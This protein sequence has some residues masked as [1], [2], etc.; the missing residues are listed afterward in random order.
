MH[1]TWARVAVAALCAVLLAGCGQPGLGVASNVGGHK[2]TDEQAAS[3]ADLLCALVAVD[4][5]A[6]SRAMINKQALASLID[7]ELTR[8]YAKKE[9][10]TADPTLVTELSQ[11]GLTFVDQLPK[12]NRE[13][14][15]DLL[16]EIST[17]RAI[18]LAAGA[19]LTNQPINLQQGDQLLQAGGMGRLKFEKSV[20]IQTAA[21]FAPDKKG[22]PGEGNGSVSVAKSKPA[23]AAL[24]L[25]QDRSEDQAWAKALPASQRCGG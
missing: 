11:Q 22:W 2:I 12:K 18:L 6:A 17:S 7:L 9:K 20:K 5:R 25:G 16:A 21:R 14:F 1:K 19:R 23:K 24:V 13:Q 10:L 15:K 4:G 8:Q 3:A